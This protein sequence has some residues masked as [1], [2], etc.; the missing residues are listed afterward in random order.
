MI[1]AVS[2]APKKAVSWSSARYIDEI[3]RSGKLVGVVL[4]KK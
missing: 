1:L 2:S 3:W 4:R